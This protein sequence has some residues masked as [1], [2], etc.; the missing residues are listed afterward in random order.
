MV[1]YTMDNEQIYKKFE[2]AYNDLSEPIFR[3]CY[4]RIYDRLRAQ[5]ITQDV[6]MKT[7]D[8]IRKGNEVHNLR[9]FI[10]K[11][12]HNLIVNELVRRK[13]T[14]SLDEMFEE[15]GFDPESD[16]DEMEAIKNRLDGEQALKR[17]K[18][19]DPNYREILYMRYID[20]LSVKEIAE[21]VG[22]KENTVSVR[23]HRGLEKLRQMYKKEIY[24]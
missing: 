12:A 24:E 1:S 11:V 3:H 10:Y 22:E 20:E 2:N 16:T 15:S 7:W 9:A 23:I 17:L 4:F 5:E 13:Q 19:L 21:L 14:Q 8:Y 6:F 18:D